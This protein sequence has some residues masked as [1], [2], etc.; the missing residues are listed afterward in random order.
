M[1]ALSVFGI[2]IDASR[3]KN[4]RTVSRGPAGERFAGIVSNKSAR[5]GRGNE[6]ATISGWQKSSFPS[7]IVKQDG[8]KERRV[9]IGQA[10]NLH[11]RSYHR[12]PLTETESEAAAEIETGKWKLTSDPLEET[13]AVTY[14]ILSSISNSRL[15]IGHF[16]RA[17]VIAFL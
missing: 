14:Q 5:S 7:W 15:P 3:W 4:D 17:R 12:Q 9:P 13:D 6:R 2:K 11:L 8:Q 10:I 1:E 16:L